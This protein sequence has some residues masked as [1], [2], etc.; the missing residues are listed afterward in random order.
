MPPPP[1][2]AAC[3]AVWCPSHPV[4]GWRAR[5][6]LADQG[7]RRAGAVRASERLLAVL[8]CHGGRGRRGG[9]QPHSSPLHTPPLPVTHGIYADWSILPEGVGGVCRTP[10]PSAASPDQLCHGTVPG[11]TAPVYTHP[12][13]SD[14]HTLYGERGVFY[15]EG[16]RVCG[17]RTAHVRGVLQEG[18]GAHGGCAHSPACCPGKDSPGNRLC[19]RHTHFV[20]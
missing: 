16:A 2:R 5:W 9:R 3:R 10:P 17:T 19:N 18:G 7:R 4:Q 11:W 13:L 12:A 20:L 14:A 15:Q 6:N 8:G 1:F